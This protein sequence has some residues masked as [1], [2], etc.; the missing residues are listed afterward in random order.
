M[1]HRLL[2]FVGGELIERSRRFTMSSLRS[3]EF[4]PFAKRFTEPEFSWSDAQKDFSS[5]VKNS[6][7]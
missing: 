6:T 7:R 4:T 3:N 1:L 2:N 5:V